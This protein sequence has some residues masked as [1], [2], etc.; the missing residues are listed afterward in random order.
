MWATTS[1]LAFGREFVSTVMSRAYQKRMRR[2]TSDGVVLPTGVTESQGA[3]GE[4]GPSARAPSLRVPSRPSECDPIKAPPRPD[5]SCGLDGQI[6]LLVLFRRS[7]TREPGL[8]VAGE[9]A[10]EVG[11]MVANGVHRTT[12]TSAG[13]PACLRTFSTQSHQGGSALRP[14]LGPP[15]DQSHHPSPQAAP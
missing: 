14:R 4:K 9:F 7:V 6:R 1:V 13:K 12:S 11:A 10:D 5:R 8:H 2:A 3:L 15:R